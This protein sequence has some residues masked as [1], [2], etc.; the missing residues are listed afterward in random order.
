M[1]MIISTRISDWRIIN[2]AFARYIKSLPQWDYVIDVK[3]PTRSIEQNSLY[4]SILEQ[5]E[6]EIG[7]HKDELHDFFKAKFLSRPVMSALWEYTSI[8]S[9]TAL[10]TKEFTDYIEKIVI[11][12]AEN[13]FE[14]IM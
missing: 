5:I 4:W 14:I 3:K 10:D 8:V 6:N 12:C 11:F 9:T 2:S 13:E 7:T 1:K